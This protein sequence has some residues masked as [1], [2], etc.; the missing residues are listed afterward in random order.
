[1]EPPLRQ[2]V[3]SVEPGNPVKRQRHAAEIRL[4]CRY[5]RKVFPGLRE[6]RRVCEPTQ[7]TL[8]SGAQKC[9]RARHVATNYHEVRI[10]N[11]YQARNRRPENF[12]R[13]IEHTKHDWFAGGTPRQNIIEG[14]DGLA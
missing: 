4:K 8:E 2:D 10:E 6:H 7:S 5:L 12:S 14:S 1:M 3:R 9:F 13:L 11:I